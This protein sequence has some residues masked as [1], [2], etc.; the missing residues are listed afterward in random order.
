MPLPPPADEAARIHA[1]RALRLLDTP[2]EERF[3]AITRLAAAIFQAPIAMVTMVDVNRQ[4]FKSRIGLEVC[5]TSRDISFCAHAI[6]SDVAL[7]I[8]DARADPR[9]ADNPLV[10]GEP[11]LR[12][13]AGQPLHAPGGQRVG[14]LCIA[15]QAP[16]EFPAEQRA[17][18]WQLAGMIER[19]LRAT[20]IIALQT[21]LLATQS[22]LIKAQERLHADIAEAAKYV[23]SLLP[24]AIRKPLGI[25]WRFL[26]SAVLGGDCF[27]YH[28][29]DS[30]RLAFYL[31]DVCGHGVGAAL[32]SVTLLR[33]LRSQS[34]SQVDFADPAAVL[35]ALNR[36]FPMAQHGNR[37]FTI[38]YGVLELETRRLTYASGGHPPAI[39]VHP[40]GRF[41][42]L[43]TNGIGIGLLPQ[44]PFDSRECVL[45]QGQTLYIFSDGGYEVRN[46]AGEF[47]SMEQF[48]ALL[49]Q[50]A[51]NSSG[52]LDYVLDEVRLLTGLDGFPDDASIIE[53]QIS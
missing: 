10:T 53:V 32:L 11:F 14:T 7:V 35:T 51:L 29:L 45:R 8:P 36:E 22:E 16:R 25:N 21:E 50:A 31:L 17:L 13:Y 37:Y 18:L 47:M 20:D 23:R 43:A 24:K 28:H 12:F 33:V 4:W 5:E 38:W 46:L 27:G 15:D 26:P 19:E 34:L 41:E 44:W 30:G 3:D 42:E 48:G 6:L 49:S 2:P 9:F 1:L 40:D 52:G 39:L